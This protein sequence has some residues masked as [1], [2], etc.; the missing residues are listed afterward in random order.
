[1]FKMYFVIQILFE[2]ILNNIEYYTL[3]QLHITPGGAE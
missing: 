2:S 3:Q 1:M